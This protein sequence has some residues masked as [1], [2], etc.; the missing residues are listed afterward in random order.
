MKKLKL[1]GYVLMAMAI[2]MTTVACGDDD[3]DNNTK[4]ENTA[5]KNGTEGADNTDNADN[6]TP[7]STPEEQKAFL[8]STARE[9]LGKV[10]ASDFKNIS[11]IVKYAN[12]NYLENRNFNSD[13]VEDW[14]DACLKVCEVTSNDNLVRRVYKAA[15][16]TG[17]FEAGSRG[18]TQTKTG[19]DVLRFTFKDAN[20]NNCVLEAK[21]S[22]SY[23]EVASPLF[24]DTDH[25]YRWN[26]ETSTYEYS[27]K[28]YENVIAVPTEIT[29]TLTRG[30]NTLVSVKV[31]TSLEVNG[32]IIDLERD[33]YNVTIAAKVNTYE[34]IVDKAIYKGSNSAEVS[35]TI[36]KNN[37]TL[38]K[39]EGKVA[40]KAKLTYKQD[41]YGDRVVDDIEVEPGEA[42]ANVNVLNKVCVE[43]KVT[44]VKNLIEV[45]DDAED[46]RYDE[47][48]FNGCL[49]SANEKID[50]KVYYQG[51]SSADSWVKLIG[52]AH[53]GNSGMKYEPTPAIFF[54]DETRYSFESFFD[55]NT[56]KKV[57]ENFETLL[58][59]FEDLAD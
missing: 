37:E 34:V 29:V 46:F 57:I 38:V 23:K 26:P 14:F 28:R 55:E 43:G 49:A 10:Q 52:S 24:D 2:S 11:D 16:F 56:F 58:R 32:N 19:G 31:N 42:W 51:K 13:P 12:E 1:F 48:K 9:L 17:C 21:A 33:N 22:D 27:S 36:K 41:Y 8:E 47:A 40:G 44:S 35:T 45:L 7:T 18:W 15:N 50:M 53:R 4:Q 3:D 59:D 39:V 25:K 54:A 6:T 20:G 30:S 5:N